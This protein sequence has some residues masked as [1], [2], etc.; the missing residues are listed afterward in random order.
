MQEL[1]DNALLREYVER[2]SGEAF[3]A[4]V[5][6]HVNTVYSV[7]LRHT[8][9]E[10]SAG[11]IAQA[12]F[13]ILAQKARKLDRRV[14]LSGWLYQTARLTA[15]TRIRSEIRRS[16]REQEAHMQTVLNEKEPDVW[17]QIAPLLDAGMAGLSEADR[18]AVVLR[19]FDGKSMNEVGAALGASEDAAK[20][21][22][23]RAVEKLR[24]FFTRRGV[25][26]P[27]TILTATISANSVQAAPVTLAKAATAVALAKGATASGSTLTLIKGALKVMA[28][29][30]A[31]TAVIAGSIVLL[32]AGT[33]AVVTATVVRDAR[34]VS[35]E[36]TYEKLWAMTTN[37][38]LPSIDSALA[39]LRK[40]PPTLIVRPTHYPYGGGG[41]WGI[42]EDKGVVAAAS[43]PLLIEIAYDYK[44]RRM[45]LP[46]AM[47]AGDYDLMATL[48]DNKNVAAL[49]DEIKRQFGIV[50]HPEI[51]ET[52]VLVLS[53]KNPE[54]LRA[55]LS[56]E[57]AAGTLRGCI[58]DEKN[59]IVNFPLKN[60]RL[61]DV[62]SGIS[63]IFEEPVVVHDAPT[64][65]YDFNFQAKTTFSADRTRQS[66]RGQ[67]LQ[68]GLEIKPGHEPVE[69][70][71]VEKIK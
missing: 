31:K 26:V 2:D 71:V 33:T 70:L 57:K 39:A 65:R 8:R 47:P 64:N 62:A 44:H 27:M 63:D 42:D 16:R 46:D 59:Q 67:L 18:H 24:R 9:N 36:E 37:A 38:N 21:R 15:V 22:V 55:S 1:D 23:N 25:V 52:N 40:A 49:K 4:L 30:K 48:S 13:V 34:P 6:R 29:T 60:V 53:V 20:K 66:L 51:R 32:T 5:E 50:A 69:M 11:E 7:A 58:I 45:I 43:V 3:A 10:H 54:R 61:E 17:T 19:F 68:L 35:A 41:A 28:W 12:V 56:R 14:I